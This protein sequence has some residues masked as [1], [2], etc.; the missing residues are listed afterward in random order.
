V[1]ELS[2]EPKSAPYRVLAGCAT[3]ALVESTHGPR[4]LAASFL[5]GTRDVEPA[6]SDALMRAYLGTVAATPE[7]RSYVLA[8]DGTR[9]PLRG[10]LHAPAY[11]DL[12][13]PGSP[14]E[15]VLTRLARLRSSLSFD[16]EPALATPT[17]RV[18]SFHA[19]ARL[20]LR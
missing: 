13:V 4:E 16:D 10:T 9:D 20:E 15:R 19:R 8:P 5:L 17:E 1:Q 14:V 18:L 6:A 3:E 12:P 2:G 11:P 7:G